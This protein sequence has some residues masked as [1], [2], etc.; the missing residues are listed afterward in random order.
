MQVARKI[1]YN[2][3]V[4]SVAKVIST[5][6]ALVVI[7]LI[8]RYLG[9]NGFGDYATVLAFFSFF[10][11]LTDLGLYSISTREISRPGADEEKIMSNIFTLR[12][13][14]SLIILLLSPIIVMF[15]PYSQEVKYAIIVVAGAYLFSSAYQILNGVFQKNL[16]MDRVAIAELLGRILQVVIVIVAVKLKLSFSWIIASMLFYMVFSF[17]LVHIWSRKFIRIRLRFDFPYWKSFLRQSYPIGIAAVITFIYFKIDTIMLSVMKSSADVGIYNAAYK[18]IENITFFPGMLVGLIFPIM[19]QTIFHDRQKFEDISN[20]TFKV[21]VI[22]VVPMVIGT[23]FL[24][25]GIIRIIGGAGFNESALVLRILI[26]ALAFIFFGNFFNVILLSGNLQK[27]LMVILA[28]AAVFN[29]SANLF[30]IPRFSYLGAACISVL[31]EAFV[32]IATFYLCAKKLNYLPSPEKAGAIITAG[33]AMAVF[34][35]FG[36]GFNFFLSG[37]ASFFVYLFFLWILKGVRTSD[38][39]SIISKKGVEEYEQPIS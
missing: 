38:I 11:A 3:L 15:F 18:V 26:F 8:T 12:I 34:L 37:L 23:M 24:S 14:S 13:L 35:Y 6:L 19:A 16:A 17:L 22:T 28:I 7:G 33:L 29:I 2:V 30:L 31:T 25:N 5:A 21:F 1:A 32:T 20:K 39:T 27:K 4:S 36:R 9:K 10:V